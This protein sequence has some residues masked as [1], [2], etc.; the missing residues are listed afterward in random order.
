MSNIKNTPI[1]HSK[2]FYEL[3]IPWRSN[4]GVVYECLAIRSFTDIYKQGQD[5]YKTFY[6]PMGLVTGSVIPDTQKVFDFKEESA[7]DPNII[8]LKGSDGTTLYIPDTFIIKSPDSTLIPYSQVV[9]G[10]SLGALPDSL[11]LGSLAE[12]VAALVATRIGVNTSVNIG[13]VP[14]VSNPTM[15]EHENLERIRTKGLPIV[16]PNT[17]MILDS[18]LDELAVANEKIKILENA[19]IE[20]GLVDNL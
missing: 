9:F 2:G 8:T 4:K 12:D 14:L 7:L 17:Q 13:V 20:N 18:T 10:V 11:A 1:I 5:V 16:I 3:A 19:F 15:D 6:L